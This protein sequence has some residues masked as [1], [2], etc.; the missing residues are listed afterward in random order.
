[1]TRPTRYQ[2]TRLS[3]LIAT[4]LTAAVSLL[5]A[6]GC[7]LDTVEFGQIQQA[8]GTESCPDP[9]QCNVPYTELDTGAHEINEIDIS[10]TSAN[11]H[12]VTF[13]G[14]KDATG[15][16]VT[17]SVEGGEFVA[18]N[19]FGGTVTGASL[20]GYVIE[21]DVGGIVA[22]LVDVSL[23][24][25]GYTQDDAWLSSASGVVRIAKYGLAQNVG[26]GT[27]LTAQQHI[28]PNQSDPTAA[29]VFLLMGETYDPDNIAVNANQTNWLTL[30]CEGSALAKMALLNYGPQSDFDGLGNAATADQR[31]ATLKMITADYCG[32]GESF[33]VDG[34][35]LYW[36]NRDDNVSGGWI[37]NAA[38][39]ALWDE[40]GATCLDSTRLAGEDVE[41]IR[42]KCENDYHVTLP[43]C[44]S[45]P[46][47][48]PNWEWQTQPVPNASF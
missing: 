40:N 20:V 43:A 47:T 38:L 21:L 45:D 46:S 23:E 48:D 26:T 15:N 27:P 14:F 36:R 35:Q 37:S 11:S 30:A 29:S 12:A 39:E 1:M 44:P 3:S 41:D 19:G 9:I 32:V 18:T 25:T 7:A 2:S 13:A 33:T 8:E 10:G 4:G 24:I 31:Q 5:G 22:P 34:A 28:C 42:D 16:P 17:L 6:A